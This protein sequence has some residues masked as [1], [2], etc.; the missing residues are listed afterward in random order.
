MK[1]WSGVVGEDGVE[2]QRV[3][4][5]GATDGEFFYLTPPALHA[6]EFSWAPD[7]RQVAFVAAD[8]PG[9]NNWWVAKLY[10][11]SFSPPVGP[12]R[13]SVSQY[14]LRRRQGSLR[15]QPRQTGPLHGLQSQFPATPRTAIK[16]PSSEAS[17]PTRALS[18]A[19]ST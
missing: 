8:P 15:T 2:I 17:C 9:E 3:A 6:Y 4:A 16:S 12:E 18:E 5:V 11:I 13:R 1:P 14:R 7:S 19:T 10:T